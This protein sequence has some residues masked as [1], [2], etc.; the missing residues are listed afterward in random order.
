MTSMILRAVRPT[1]QEDSAN[2]GP[3]RV[4]AEEI[5]FAAPTT[6]LGWLAVSDELE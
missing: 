6:P 2:T 3:V 4:P 5:A 1:T